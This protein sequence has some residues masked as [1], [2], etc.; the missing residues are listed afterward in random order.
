VKAANITAIYPN[1]TMAGW[2]LTDEKGGARLTLME[3]VMNSTGDYPVGNYTVEAKYAS[4]SNETTMN[5]TQ[6]WQVALSLADLVIPEFPS[7]QATMFFILLTLLTV[8][9]CKKKG[10]KTSQ[11]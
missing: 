2:K 3:K 10:V 8:I 1:A 11:S 9:I 6:N 7:I 4:Y 5:M